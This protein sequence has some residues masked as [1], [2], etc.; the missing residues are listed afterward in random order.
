[1]PT[2][3]EWV[4][5]EK[6]FH[7]KSIWEPMPFD[8]TAVNLNDTEDSSGKNND[9]YE[10][11]LLKGRW[12]EGAEGFQFNKKCKV[13]VEGKFLKKT[14][15]TRVSI[16]TFSTFRDEK[17]NEYVKEPL[18]Q[19]IEANLEKINKDGMEAF[20]EAE[21]MLYYGDKYSKA[22]G[23]KS[24]LTCRY[25]FTA[26][27]NVAKKIMEKC[28]ELE[29]PQTEHIDLKKGMYDDLAV[30]TYQS[31][32]AGEK[33]HIK[34]QS[35]KNLQENLKKIGNEGIGN[36]DGDFGDKTKRAVIDFQKAAAEKKRMKKD[37]TFIDV[38]EVL[39]GY[40][41]GVFNKNC[42]EEM[43]KWLQNGYVLPQ[44]YLTFPGTNFKYKKTEK[45]YQD[46]IGTLPSQLRSNFKK[47]IEK[48]IKEMHDL[49]FALGVMESAKAGYRTFQTQ[50]DIDPTKTKAGPGESFHNYGLAV[51]LGVLNWV[52]DEG[53]SYNDFWLGK[54]NAIEKYKGFSA[55]IWQKRNSFCGS[56][57]HSLSFETI[58]LQG[59]PKDKSGRSALVECLNKAAAN[60]NDS[61]WKYKKASNKKY[62]CNLG[63]AN[64]WKNVGTA[65][66]MW[67][68]NA[69]NCDKEQKK[70]IKKHMK[71]SETV[72]LTIN[73]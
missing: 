14:N 55:K 43:D 61:S 46:C 18:G 62:E 58:H 3:K 23:E 31:R 5:D 59:V 35:I 34:D 42:K 28:E 37:K 56:N 25:T 49:G 71:D 27:S 51:D 40:S 20:A 45:T 41:E 69:T 7:A 2:R 36:I 53:Q 32:K 67:S 38:K 11:E 22:L 52:D 50:N 73:V 60:L 70:K 44:D 68:E 64:T 54:M 19:T 65:K 10:V 66:Q 26:K 21:V 12:L 63:T 33:G 29:V 8:K 72:A 6:G 57:V 30:K 16:N 47:N 9:K 24:D 39:S 48:I 4:I 17:K 13:R 15:R 1:M